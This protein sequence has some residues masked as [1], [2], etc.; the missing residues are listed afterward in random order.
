MTSRQHALFWIGCAL[1]L[2]A[3]LV[4]LDRIL[5]P[6]V[7]GAAIAYLLDPLADR[8]ERRGFSRLWATLV[9][10]TI[11]TLALILV[12]VLVVPLLIG[13]AVSLVGELPSYLQTLRNVITDIG[14]RWGERAA[15]TDIGLQ[16]AVTQLANNAPR[17]VAQLL[18]SLW[19][20]GLAFFNFLALIFVT[21]I[22]S[23]YLL[24]DWDRMIKRID[25]WLPREQASTIRALARE[26][27]EVISGFVRG[28]ILV[29]ILLS[30]IYVV[31]LVLIGLN[32]GLLIGLG[33]GLVSFVPYLGPLVGYVVGGV[34][35]VVQ[36]WPEWGWILAVLGV[37]AVGQV[38]EGNILSPMILGDKVHLHPVWLIFALF[39]FAYLFGFVGLVLAVPVAAAIGVLVRFALHRY[40]Q[41][42]LYNGGE[43]DKPEAG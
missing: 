19:S 35:A 41:S 13:Q 24:R 39:A 12:L 32:F 25:S 29:L 7:L 20:G 34:V 14:E 3:L 40:L 15:E 37:F 16:G 18:S 27:D 26:M 6:F 5:L 2:L 11:F 8:L 22:V 43:P 28:Q 23:F 36:F 1:I 38:I 17:L 30:V 42:S 21:P 31:G 4:L 33:A 9:I 10:L